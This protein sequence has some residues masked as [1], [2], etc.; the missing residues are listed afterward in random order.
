MLAWDITR[1]RIFKIKDGDTEQKA[2]IGLPTS[3]KPQQKR[4]RVQ[5]FRES[6]CYTA[7]WSYMIVPSECDDYVFCKVCDDS[8][9]I[10]IAHGGANAGND[11][12]DDVSHE[13]IAQL[14]KL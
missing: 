11:H 10:G 7:K 3:S 14:N 2:E 6:Y 1:W 9:S 4:A 13:H 12:D 5:L 8:F